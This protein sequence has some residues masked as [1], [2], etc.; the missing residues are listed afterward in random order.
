MPRY[1]AIAPFQSSNPEMFNKVW[2]FDL[3]SNLISIG[4]ARVGNVSNMG[5]DELANAV[6]T[7]C[8]DSPPQT[9]GLIAN[10][11]WAFYHEILP[12][13]CVIA[14]RGQKTLAAVG[15]VTACATYNLGRNPL[16][17]APE[18]AHPSF[19]EVDWQEVPR[20]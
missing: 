5:R 15:R 17:A 10:M 12:G 9:L 3:S 13:D 2:Q 4:W 11:L 7:A 1:W 6:A 20:D 18:H 8:P 19:L 16:L 14:R